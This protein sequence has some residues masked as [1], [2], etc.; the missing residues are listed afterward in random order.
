MVKQ[1]RDDLVLSQAMGKRI[2]KPNVKARAYI[3]RILTQLINSSG[4]TPNDVAAKIGYSR[5]Q[6]YK[7]M[8]GKEQPSIDLIGDI[9]EACFTSLEQW[10]EQR[11]QKKDAEIHKQIQMILDEVGPGSEYRIALERLVHSMWASLT[12]D[13]RVRHK[14]QK[15]L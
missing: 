9:F 2:D 13:R 11:P 15:D 5:Q 1:D 8:A 10:V 7:A 4:M 3:G 14:V 12:A 6:V